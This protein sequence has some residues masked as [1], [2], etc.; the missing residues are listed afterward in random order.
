[1]RPIHIDYDAILHPDTI[2][3]RNVESQEKTACPV[4]FRNEAATERASCEMG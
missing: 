3:M 1:M 2:D 4:V